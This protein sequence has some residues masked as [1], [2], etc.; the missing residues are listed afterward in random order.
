MAS[1]KT[2]DE[3]LK[4]KL[5][6]A[7]FWLSERLDGSDPQSDFRL[8]EKW[9]PQHIVGLAATL[10]ERIPEGF[11]EA[12]HPRLYEKKIDREFARYAIANGLLDE[13]MLGACRRPPLWRRVKRYVMRYHGRPLS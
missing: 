8:M 6:D 4:R 9:P 2:E 1:A 11:R 7:L 3:S 12:I 10:Q 5:D 13:A